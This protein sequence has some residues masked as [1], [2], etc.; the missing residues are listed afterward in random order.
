M[1]IELSPAEAEA[2]RKEMDRWLQGLVRSV[3]QSV[4][5]HLEPAATKPRFDP[6]IPRQALENFMKNKPMPRIF[7]EI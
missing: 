7:P 5:Q 3:A 1:K 2:Y 6:N 4:G